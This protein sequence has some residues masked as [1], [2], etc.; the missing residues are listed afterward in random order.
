MNHFGALNSEID[1]LKTLDLLST[2]EKAIQ[3]VRSS[4]HFARRSFGK[5]L[6]S[7]ILA[8]VATFLVRFS[9]YNQLA[10][11]NKLWNQ[12]LLTVNA[13]RIYN[14]LAL[15]SPILSHSLLEENPMEE[16]Q[17]E[18][19]QHSHIEEFDYRRGS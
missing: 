4:I 8:N 5:A 6:P 13:Q 1:V 19:P 2:G 15:L 7:T 9:V 10:L 17:M 14:R 3:M 11:I 18:L 16:N 12:H